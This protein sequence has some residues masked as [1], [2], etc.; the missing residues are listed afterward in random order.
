MFMTCLILCACSTRG[1]PST[2][3]DAQSL[4]EE[5]EVK[6]LQRAV[7][8]QVERISFA[9]IAEGAA[10][11]DYHART[12][13]DYKPSYNEDPAIPVQ[14]WIET[15]YGTQNACKY[16][17]TNSLADM[18]HGNA[19]PL[20][21][22][23]I[24]YSF[25]S[26]NLNRVNWRNV[27]A[28]QEIIER[29]T[30]ERIEVPGAKDPKCAAYVRSDNW[31]AA[32]NKARPKGETS[33]NNPSNA[34]SP[35]QL[36]PA[37]NPDDLY[38][39][40]GDDPTKGGRHGY[41]DGEGFVRNKEKGYT[42]WRAVNFFP[43]AI[44]TPLTGS[45]SGIYIRL[46]EPFMQVDG[47]LNIETYRQNLELLEKNIKN[48]EPGSSF[49]FGDANEVPVKKGFYPK[50][51]E[52]AHPLHYVDLNADGQAGTSLDGVHPRGIED[53]E[54]PGTRSKRVKEIRYMYK[55][56][57]V[58]LDD[59]AIEEE[60]E[61]HPAVLGKEW[62]GWIENG[63]GWILAAF[64][65]SRTGE[66]RPQTTEELLQCLG[67]H[68][69]VGN[70]VDA[71][72]SFQRKLPGS[73]GW[74]EM[75]YG[76]YQKEV[77]ERTRL[78][79]YYNAD[80]DMGELEYFYYT[81]IGADLFGIMPDE[82]KRELLV[83]AGEKDLAA[84]LDLKNPLELLF[85]DHKL[86]TTGKAKRKE[87]VEERTLIMRDFASS[88]EYLY[89]DGASGKSYIKGKLFYP[90]IST[91]LSNITSYRRIVLDQSF[92]LG[93]NTFG[94]QPDAIPFTFRSDGTVKNG[95]GN[96]IPLGEVIASRPWGA[97]G[98]GTTPTGIVKVN[99]E[100]EPLDEHGEVV[101]IEKHPERAIGHISRGGT[102]ETRYNPI[103]TDTP[104]NKNK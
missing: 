39:M 34:S 60:E 30:R 80:Q 71:V 82:I 74:G 84:K 47:S 79:D 37:L 77:P 6:A 1:V 41:V 65:E 73:A 48:Q 24:L 7:G 100:G 26:P 14:C 28:P 103:L 78:Q 13:A 29:L 91:M 81:V 50:G 67:C 69:S 72:W 49:Y 59:I 98:I 97:D 55:W 36:V 16:C 19:A 40:K 89:L 57:D 85:D 53:Y 75:D 15:G 99:A 83:Y 20:A 102:F 31:R 52:F 3:A 21:E 25:P 17:H 76:Q 32:Y 33:W 87:I 58:D 96:I 62:K 46:P 104:V 70:T 101:D 9:R 54:F 66:I 64:I 22:D 45:V 92:N 44:F 61:D 4:E 35:L 8:L 90:S 12:G 95:E 43:Y 18:G 63:A 27:I 51:T 38:P 5:A 42:G 93:K 86:K 2:K 56:E 23:Q 11:V 94:S 88:R 68:S 10:P